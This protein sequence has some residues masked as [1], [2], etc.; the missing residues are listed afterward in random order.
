MPAE[1]Y[2]IRA[3]GAVAK[4]GRY[5]RMITGGINLLFFYITPKHLFFSFIIAMKTKGKEKMLF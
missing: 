3:C 1:P 4:T 5:G 2:S